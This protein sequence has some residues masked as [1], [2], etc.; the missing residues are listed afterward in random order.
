MRVVVV[1]ATGNMGT[2]LLRALAAE[3]ALVVAGVARRIPDRPLTA[4]PDVEWHSADVA[5]SDLFPLF[6]GADVVVHLAWEIQPSRNVDQLQRTNVIGSEN[7]FRAV[8]EAR[9]PSLGPASS[10]G[11]RARPEG[12]A[13]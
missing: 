4:A 2:A 12:P 5:S 10:V 9:V 6:R 1:G 13:C 7:V 11:L 8:V 3:P